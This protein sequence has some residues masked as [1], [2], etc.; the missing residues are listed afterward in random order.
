MID[1]PAEPQTAQVFYDR[2][3][4]RL[5]VRMEMT[6]DEPP[7]EVEITAVIVELVYPESSPNYGVR[8]FVRPS[9]GGAR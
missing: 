4:A 3:T 1:Q 6:D 2:D 7:T 8:N 9:A 5:V